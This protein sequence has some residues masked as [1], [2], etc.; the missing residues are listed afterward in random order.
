MK[1]SFILILLSVLS[2]A[3]CNLI[4]D[5]G[6]RTYK[7]YHYFENLEDDEYT[8]NSKLTQKLKGNLN[9]ETAAEALDIE[10]FTPEDFEQIILVEKNSSV[11]IYYKRNISTLTFIGNGGTTTATNAEGEE[12]TLEQVAVTGKYGLPVEEPVF[13]RKSFIWKGW[14]KEVPETIPASD[15]EITGLWTA[16]I[17]NSTNRYYVRPVQKFVGSGMQEVTYKICWDYRGG[18]TIGNQIAIWMQKNP[19]YSVSYN[20]FFYFEPVE[21]KENTYYIFSRDDGK[22][23][24][25]ITENTKEYDT[26]ETLT[27]YSKT[28]SINGLCPNKKSEKTLQFELISVSS[29]EKP[30]EEVFALKIS[31]TDKYVTTGYSMY[32]YYSN[33]AYITGIAFE[34]SC[35]IFDTLRT[36]ENGDIDDTQLFYLD[37]VDK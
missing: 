27:Q 31:G 22:T 28:V 20:Q 24:Y 4:T 18:L 36:K 21:D 37:G 14:D 25:Y 8:L 19:A 10:G 15:T 34:E 7:V 33:P 32:E 13:T 1:K 2:L 29:S 12:E 3:S 17:I 30:N 35:L 11:S 6:T 9:E 26:K 5:N 23:V 16:D